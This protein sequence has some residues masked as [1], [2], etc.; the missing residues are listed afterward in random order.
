MVEVVAS[1]AWTVV[2]CLLRGFLVVVL[3]LLNLKKKSGL[4]LSS[5]E[6]PSKSGLNLQAIIRL[7]LSTR[8][9]RFSSLLLM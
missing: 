2:D 3:G 8:S 4:F 7:R 5:G 6:H 9:M 1:S